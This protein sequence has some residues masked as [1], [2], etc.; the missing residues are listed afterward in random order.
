MHA[1]RVAL[2]AQRLSHVQTSRLATCHVRYSAAGMYS[3]MLVSMR[4][5]QLHRTWPW[6]GVAEALTLHLTCA[7]AFN[8]PFTDLLQ[9]GTPAGAFKPAEQVREVFD[10][11]GVD[12]SKPCICTCGSGATAAVLAHALM[13][14]GAP[15][16]CI[17]LTMM[18]SVLV[19]VG[20]P[21]TSSDAVH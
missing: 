21:Y 19:C 5:N 11:A 8:V 12:T 18:A 9:G 7:G 17:A 20:M 13:Q 6:T 1:L 14:I 2:L 16:V 15:P 10:S 3:I 4:R